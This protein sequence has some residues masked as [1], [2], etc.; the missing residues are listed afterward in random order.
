M[1]PTRAETLDLRRL[2]LVEPELRDRIA[3]DRT[4]F[5]EESVA[6]LVRTLSL[7][8]RSGNIQQARVSRGRAPRWS[9]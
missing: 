1:P 3:Y 6:D 7:R 5:V 9:P 4:V 2:H 8:E